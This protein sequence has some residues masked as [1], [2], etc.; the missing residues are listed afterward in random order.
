MS[1]NEDPHAPNSS[2]SET[3]M[4]P[5]GL[6]SPILL[7][8]DKNPDEDKNFEVLS[9]NH[10]KENIEPP[11]EKLETEESRQGSG[12]RDK[13]KALFE[14]EGSSDVDTP[15]D[16]IPGNQLPDLLI[17]VLTR[18]GVISGEFERLR[19]MVLHGLAATRERGIA[20]GKV[21]Q[22]SHAAKKRRT[23]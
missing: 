2:D 21:G 17:D 12:V 22:E 4:A 8:N 3:E 14:L 23:Q 19:S 15:A 18:I 20:T 1:G 9:D 7:T 6:G 10:D 16:W 5:T 11:R 13:R